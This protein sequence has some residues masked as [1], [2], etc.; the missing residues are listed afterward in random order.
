MKEWIIF[1]GLLLFAGGCLQVEYRF[2]NNDNLW[3]KEAEVIKAGTPEVDGCGWLI[4]INGKLYYPVNL[5][6]SFRVE[7]LRVKIEFAETGGIFRCGRR[8]TPFISIRL[9]HIENLKTKNEVGILHKYQL[10][11]L[12]MD[13]FRM[14]SAY[15]DGDT[16]R[17]KVSYSGGC[18]EHQFRLW[19]LPPN[20]LVPPPV[21][22]LLEHDANGD[23]CEAWLTKN[24]AY[25]LKPL[26]IPGK[27]EVTFLL[28]GS[29]EMSA[30]FGRFVYKY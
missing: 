21:E 6:D 4:R 14:D 18:R 9:F 5:A 17:L 11:E 23:L 28:R 20:A 27:H 19:K 15:V 13:G 7:N 2:D 10:D 30:Y 8:G 1:A 26:R 12:K 22:L 29:P 3:I 24:L 25:S 16:I